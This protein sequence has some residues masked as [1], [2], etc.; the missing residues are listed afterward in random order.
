M[1]SAGGSAKQARDRKFQAI[2]PVFG[3]ILN[4]EKSTFETAVK[5]IKLQ[6]M[7]KALGCG[8]GNTFNIDKLR[9]HRIILMSDADTDGGHI[10]CLHMANIFRTMKPIIERGYLYAA[11]P[12]LYRAIKKKGKTNETHYFYNDEELSKFNTEGYAISRFKGLA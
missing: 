1:D 12:P 10:Q 4:I 5:S 11:C 9:F 7:I 8:I 2:L 3:K 6:D